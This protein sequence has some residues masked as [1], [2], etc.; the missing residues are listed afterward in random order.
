MQ[1]PPLLKVA[2]GRA[3]LLQELPQLPLLVSATDAQAMN[4]RR[5]SSREAWTE[6]SHDCL[7]HATTSC[8]RRRLLSGV[9]P[10][11][12]APVGRLKT[13]TTAANCYR[14]ESHYLGLR[15]LKSFSMRDRVHRRDGAGDPGAEPGARPRP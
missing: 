15:R 4:D 3:G 5:E 1:F 6:I 10:S 7:A 13:I 9:Q 2:D 12:D 11:P 14:N 8:R